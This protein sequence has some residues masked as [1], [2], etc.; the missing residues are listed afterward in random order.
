MTV[1]DVTYL[2][3][4]YSLDMEQALS[5]QQEDIQNKMMREF[6]DATAE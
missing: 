1:G 3:S 6:R 5:L 2:R 4:L